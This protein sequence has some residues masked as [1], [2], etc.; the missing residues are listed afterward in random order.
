[1]ESQA[2]EFRRL[3]AR[4][5]IVAAQKRDGVLGGGKF[6]E[7]SRFSFP[8]LFDEDRKVTKA[9]GVY[10]LIGKDA[11]NIARPS[12]FIINRSGTI[13]FVHVASH[14]KERPSAEELIEKLKEHGV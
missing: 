11:F 7:R 4:L 9:Y 1:M 3:G 8:L 13:R 5:L 10:H 12:T 6:A 14:Q 2:E